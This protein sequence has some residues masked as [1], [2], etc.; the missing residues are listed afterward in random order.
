MPTIPRTTAP[1]NTLTN[2]SVDVLNAIR[3]SATTNYQNYVPLATASADSIREIGA[4]IMDNP[5]LQN[6]FLN[7]LVN[8]IGR[9]ILTS[10]LYD[11]P[12]AMFKKGLLEFGETVEEIFV[13]LAQP[14]QY[15]PEAAETTVFQR[16]KPD[17]HAAFHV[18][19]Y[20]KF[21]KQTIQNNDLRLAFLSWNGVTELIAKIVDAMYSAA[22]YDEFITMKYMLAKAILN[23]QVY[24]TTIP[25]VE[26][27][28]MKGIVSTVKG[29]SNS[30]EFMSDKYNIAGVRTYAN[31]DDQFIILNAK[32]QAEMDVEVLA[33][34]F[35]MDRAQFF[36]HLVMIDS[37]GT[38]DNARLA[39][40]FAND[41]NYTE[42]PEAS[43]QALDA[44][45]AVLVSR[46]W[47]MVF[48]NLH[49]FGEIYNSDGLYW[50]YTFHKWSTFSISP[51]APATVFVPGTPGVT[52]VTV[53]PGTATVT[54]GQSIQLNATVVTSNFAPQTVTW[55]SNNT[56][57]TV[58][59]SGLVM[60]DSAATGNATITAT[61]VYDD[62]KKG[63]A[64]LTIS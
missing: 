48:D 23:G 6:E 50:N 62:T 15:N 28:N 21:Y 51:F 36:G 20:Q 14:F 17:V 57:V 13:D 2:A 8:R 7:A 16:V 64:T 19:N 31:K 18:L 52:S 25:T 46:D 54:K 42:I 1:L 22:N 30:L 45:P 63:S 24:P 55:T 35:N 34:A 47:F 37:F 5:M 4:I 32:F 43:L 33:A 26:T 27:D 29:V 58:S 40:L 39:E 59:P 41:P 53:N 10:K 60:V 9:V 12:W 56:N 11:N 61:S 44:I 3:N 49:Q 38:T